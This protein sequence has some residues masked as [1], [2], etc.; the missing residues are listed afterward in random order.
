M[1]RNLFFHPLHDSSDGTQP[2]DARTQRLMEQLDA[3]GALHAREASERGVAD[4]VFAA[5][6]RELSNASAPR[7]VARIGWQRWAGVL[8][9]AAVLGMAVV[10]PMMMQ[11]PSRDSSLVQAQLA[12]AGLSEIIVVGLLDDDAALESFDPSSEEV[13]APVA[14]TRS[15]RA[16]QVQGEIQRLLALGGDR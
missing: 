16:E 1:N 9:A 15:H 14:M 5:S 3:L 11:Q 13:M 2:S 4:R 8:G 6:M 10:V 12:P 7:V